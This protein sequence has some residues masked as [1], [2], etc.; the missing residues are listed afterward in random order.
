MLEKRT[1][2][3]CKLCNYL[4]IPVCRSHRLGF[5][6]YQDLFTYSERKKI[7]GIFFFG[8]CGSAQGWLSFLNC[9]FFFRVICDEADP[10]LHQFCLLEPIPLTITQYLSCLRAVP[11]L[12]SFYASYSIFLEGNWGWVGSLILCA[13]LFF[14][15][16]NWI[17]NLLPFIA[18]SDGFRLFFTL[19]GRK[20]LGFKPQRF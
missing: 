17:S 9:I 16:I 7:L 11:T 10:L 6:P 14:K 18:S 15:V 2:W 20:E 1:A 4:P 12:Y 19:S 5:V 8:L 13:I 3:T